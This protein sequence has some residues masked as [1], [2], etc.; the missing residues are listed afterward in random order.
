MSTTEEKAE[1]G[2]EGQELTFSEAR[3]AMRG[4]VKAREWEQFHTP[5]N[6]V[7]ALVGEVGEVAEIFQW[8]GE[9]AEGLPTFSEEEKRNVS[10]ELADVLAY[11]VRLADVCHVDLAQAFKAKLEKNNRKYP[12]EL[13]KGSSKKYTEY[14]QNWSQEK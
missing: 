13:V 11:L 1:K 6:L 2:N 5:R 9:V 4:F 8:K 10:D 7:M 3:D 12:A 14:K